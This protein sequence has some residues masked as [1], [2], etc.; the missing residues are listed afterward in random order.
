MSDLT[1][2]KLRAVYDSLPKPEPDLFNPF[3]LSLRPMGREVFI[4]PSPSPKIQVRDIKFADGTSLLPAA[5]L[6]TENAW[7]AAHFGYQE[8]IFKDKIYLLGSYAMVMN[9]RNHSILSSI[10]P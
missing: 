10:C 1:Y 7:W 5:F 2:E 9:A 3:R 8:D 6:A 4:A